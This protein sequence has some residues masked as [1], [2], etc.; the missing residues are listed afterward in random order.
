MVLRDL[1]MS[2]W[3]VIQFIAMEFSGNLNMEKD[4]MMVHFRKGFIR[5]FM[6]GGGGRFTGGG[7]SP[8]RKPHSSGCC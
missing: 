3:E 8:P 7:G 2:R 5:H 4:S 1:S 6:D